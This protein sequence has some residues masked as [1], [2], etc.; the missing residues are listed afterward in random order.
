MAVSACS[1]RLKYLHKKI[2]G[3][4]MGAGRDLNQPASAR[5]GG[6]VSSWYFFIGHFH[7]RYPTAVVL[8]VQGKRDRRSVAT[9]GGSNY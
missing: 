6:P 8:L 5:L 9:S 2:F 1:E 4:K 7:A 3:A